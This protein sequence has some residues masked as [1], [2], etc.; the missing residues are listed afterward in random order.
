MPT[1]DFYEKSAEITLNKVYSKLIILTPVVIFWNMDTLN[2]YKSKLA[3]GNISLSVELQ[4]CFN[5]P[6]DGKWYIQPTANLLRI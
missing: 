5:E 2:E 3:D 1:V 6:Y 4:V